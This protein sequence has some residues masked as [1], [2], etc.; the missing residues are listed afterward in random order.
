M[1]GSRGAT[2]AVDVGVSHL[3]MNINVI[4]GHGLGSGLA[5]GGDK[6]TAGGESSSSPPVG[7]SE[8]LQITGVEACAAAPRALRGYPGFISHLFISPSNQKALAFLSSP[9]S[10][11]HPVSISS[12]IR[13]RSHTY[14][15]ETRPT[16]RSAAALPVAMRSVASVRSPPLLP[17]GCAPRQAL[18]SQPNCRPCWPRN[19][20]LLVQTRDGR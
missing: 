4:G 16:H 9:R 8:M 19:R 2:G 7:E 17:G 18:Y 11:L 6:N 13:F 5:S 10:T 3:N 1:D 15:V 12:T 20:K 14:N